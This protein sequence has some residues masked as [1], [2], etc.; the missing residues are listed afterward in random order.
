MPRCFYLLRITRATIVNHIEESSEGAN[1]A[2]AFVYCDYKD[3]ETLSLASIWSSIVRQL[4]ESCQHIPPEVRAF[5]LKHIE[6]RSFPSV[7]EWLALVKKL[8]RLFDKTYI[9]I[10]ALVRYWLC[11]EPDDRNS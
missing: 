9:L 11:G 4:V 10:D 8:S 6:K 5:R 3:P 1:V 2:V 7:E